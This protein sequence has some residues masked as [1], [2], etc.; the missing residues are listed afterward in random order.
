MCNTDLNVYVQSLLLETGYCPELSIPVARRECIALAV[1]RTRNID[2][3]LPRPRSE[4]DALGCYIIL[5]HRVVV[6]HGG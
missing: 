4:L 2:P 6:R 5:H 1:D 3:L